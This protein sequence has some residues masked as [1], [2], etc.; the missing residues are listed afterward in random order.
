[1]ITEIMDLQQDLPFHRRRRN[2]FSQCGEDGVV[3]YL[4][5]SCEYT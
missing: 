3:E 4:L 1:M 2:V 5:K